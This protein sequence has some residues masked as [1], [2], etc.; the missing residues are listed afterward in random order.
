MS[1]NDHEFNPR[2]A[3]LKAK[4]AGRVRQAAMKAAA[5]REASLIAGHQ[6][7]LKAEAAERRARRASTS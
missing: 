7:R 2:D 5:E 1:G 6:A 4:A 3:V